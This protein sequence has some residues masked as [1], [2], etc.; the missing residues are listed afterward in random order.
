MCIR[1]RPTSVAFGALLLLGLAC[2]DSEDL[3]PQLESE[4]PTTTTEP[5]V[6]YAEEGVPLIVLGGR[7]Y[8]TGSSRD[9]AAKGPSLLGV[10][11]VIVESYERIHRSNLIGMGVLPLQFMDGD[12]ADSLG[13]T[14]HET[15]EI[16]GIAGDFEP[17]QT[18]QVSATTDDG[19]VT[20]FDAIMRIDTGVE[21]DYYR[22][23]GVLQFVLRRMANDSQ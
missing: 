15:F 1:D 6:K 9:W 5:V 2:G 12:S 17:R 4:L 8:G 7:E 23:G 21:W 20:K 16:T 3:R 22:H 11:A 19:S 14:G 18:V 10:R 13:L